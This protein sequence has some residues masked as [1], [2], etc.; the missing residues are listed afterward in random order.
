MYRVLVVVCLAAS[1]GRHRFD[2]ISDAR[3]DAG[4]ITQLSFRGSAP[5]VLSTSGRMACWGENLSGQLGRGTASASEPPSFVPVDDVVDMATGE[6][7]AFAIDGD[8][9]LWGWGDNAESQLGLGTSTTFEATPQRVSLPPVA[10][11]AT[12]QFHSCAITTDGELYCWG[13][14]GCGALGTGMTNVNEDS[15]FRVQGVANARSVEVSDRETCYIDD[16][17]AVWCIGSSHFDGDGCVTPRL[18]PTQR[19][20]LSSIVEIVGG[21]HLSMCAID[22]TGDAWCWGGNMF[23]VGGD[24]TETPQL[25]PTPVVNLVNATDIGTGYDASCAAT[26][27]NE[28]YCWGR[29][30]LGQ[31]GVGDAQIMQTSI[32]VRLPF[33][34]GSIPIDQVEV[35]CNAT[36]A[37]S[38]SDIYCWGRNAENVVDTSGDPAFSPVLRVGLPF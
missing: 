13:Q 18:V 25:V 31:L 33:F 27:Q 20:E 22:A 12:G 29:N 4:D 30:P 38:R 1:C 19:T 24:G 6:N 35:G 26:A 7:I 34:T 23:G 11:V 36:C 16:A 10:D 14:N 8:G 5:C 21:C 32:P 3:S 2:E 9:A 15:P 37:R 17:G 28:V